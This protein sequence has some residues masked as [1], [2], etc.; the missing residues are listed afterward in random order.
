MS[1]VGSRSVMESDTVQFVLDASSLV[2]RAGEYELFFKVDRLRKLF[3]E[4]RESFQME[5]EYGR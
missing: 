4:W 1:V 2:N 3:A 5:R